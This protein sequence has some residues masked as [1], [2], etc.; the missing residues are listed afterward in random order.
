MLKSGIVRFRKVLFNF[1]LIVL[2]VQNGFGQTAAPVV[3]TSYG[4]VSGTLTEGGIYAFKGI[5]FAKPPVGNLRWQAP[6]K[7][8]AWEGIREANVF[9]PSP[10]QGAPTPFM[11]WSKEFLIP[12]TPISEDC[13]YLNVWT[14]QVHEQAKLPVVVYIY[15]GGFRSGGSACPIYDGENTAKAGV[16]YV[17]INYR[18]GI[19]GFLSHPELSEESPNKSSGNYGIQDMIAGLQWV[20]DNISQFGGDPDQV[21]IAGQS[22]GAFAVNYLTVAPEAKGLFHRAIAESGADFKKNPMG[23]G[24]SLDQAELEGIALQNEMELSGI[25]ELR[26][27]TADQL[28]KAT[29][30]GQW[31]IVDGHTIPLSVAET[32]ERGL[33]AKI[34]VLM[35]WNKEDILF[36]R[37][38]TPEEFHGDLTQRFGNWADEFK[39]AYPAKDAQTTLQSQRRLSRDETFGTQV[40]LWAKRH[41][42]P[43]SPDV[44]V[45]N[46]NRSLP[47][48][49]A[50]NEFG[51]FHSGEIVYAYNNLHTLD[52]PW[53]DADHRLTK[54][55]SAYWINFVKGGNPNGADLPI[56]PKFTSTAQHVMQLNAHS[57]AIPFEDHEVYELWGRFEANPYKSN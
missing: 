45:Y 42:G 11:F 5:P 50:E 33:Q 19:F 47:A 28:M 41:S 49:T 15:G 39:S 56:W 37:P 22:A 44:Y 35:G 23:R 2:L 4:Q 57:E 9:G 13:L 7:P 48:Y 54:I 3:S 52:R 26:N 43:E 27:L 25:S 18:V 31:P 55:M 36:V 51:A 21:T 17:S 32:Y 20:R 6:Q 16:V 10:M 24:Q 46:F 34:P 38:Q 1:G 30:G 29:K 40:Y 53:E 14:S 12:D 8:D